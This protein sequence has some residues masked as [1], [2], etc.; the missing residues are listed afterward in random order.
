MLSTEDP[1]IESH[2]FTQLI[3]PTGGVWFAAI[4]RYALD[5]ISVSKGTKQYTDNGEALEDL[6]GTREI[7][8]RLCAMTDLDVEAVAS[9]M[10]RLIRR[11]TA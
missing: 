7:L 5:C 2:H 10:V 6:Y 9:G 11:K 8:A 4:E 1:A 3:D